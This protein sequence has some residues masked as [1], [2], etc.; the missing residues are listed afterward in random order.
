MSVT[1]PKGFVAASARA[2]IKEAGED[3]ALVATEDGSAVAAAAVF[4]TNKA[5]AASVSLSRDHLRSTSGHAAAVVLTSGNANAAT[6][7]PGLR[8][9][10]RLCGLV[11]EGLGASANEV[12]LC[13]TGLIGI[14]FPIDLATQA[15][16]VLLSRRQ[17][18][19]AAARAAAE[20]IMTTD[21]VRK[22]VIVT[23]D[24]FKVGGMAK[25]AA[26][27]APNM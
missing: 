8:A 26:M 20:A 18:S 9:A 5:P 21:T 25:G 19:P 12:L 27:L 17:G 23:G 2:G 14:S 7:E 22:D 1:A 13:Q 4:T 10:E 6:G 15:V 16:P 24:G 11:G 3:M